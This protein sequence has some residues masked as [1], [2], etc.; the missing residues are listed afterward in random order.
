MLKFS[1]TFV[2]FGLIA[3]PI[4]LFAA[5]EL[6]LGFELGSILPDA[7]AYASANGWALRRLSED[8][9]NEWVVE[10][11]DGGLFVCDNTVLAVRRNFEGNVDDFA[12][13]VLE[14]TIARGAPETNIVTFL[15]GNVRISNIDARYESEDGSGVQIQLHS[16]DGKVGISTNVW[17][18]EGCAD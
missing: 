1:N 18:A 11:A 4:Q 17:S 15:A 14:T 6:Q 5:D 3:L 12:S 10:G 9:P 2:T 16:T 8:L 13:M 7:R